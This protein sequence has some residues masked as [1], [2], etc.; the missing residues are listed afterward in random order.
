[1]LLQLLSS[2]LSFLVHRQFPTTLGMMSTESV[3]T[4][5]SSPASSPPPVMTTMRQSPPVLPQ[6]GDIGE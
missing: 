4:G 3:D 2:L 6:N 1:M 5:G